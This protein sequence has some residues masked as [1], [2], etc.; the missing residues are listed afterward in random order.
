MQQTRSGGFFYAKRLD[1]P[2]LLNAFIINDLR[3][4]VGGWECFGTPALL[5]RWDCIVFTSLFSSFTPNS[6]PKRDKYM[7]LKGKKKMFLEC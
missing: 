1:V 5:S 4:K 6:Q 7:I 3:Q 2:N